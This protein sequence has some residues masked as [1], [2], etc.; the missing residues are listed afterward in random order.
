MKDESAAA[1]KG[2]TTMEKELDFVV[3]VLNVV[4]PIEEKS[5]KDFMNW[6]QPL[7][8][9][10]VSEFTDIKWT[11]IQMLLYWSR[12]TGEPFEQL[13]RRFVFQ[14]R[15]EA[16]NLRAQGGPEASGQTLEH[17]SRWRF[18]TRKQQKAYDGPEGARK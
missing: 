13:V 6:F 8:G 17:P 14:V 12:E 16:K 5:G 10:F 15:M 7:Q 18:L 11:A 3:E 2:K 1:R 9:D 4:G